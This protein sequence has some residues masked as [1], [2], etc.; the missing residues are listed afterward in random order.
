[1][2]GEIALTEEIQQL[3]TGI[4]GAQTFFSLR[5]ES[6]FETRQSITEDA[7]HKFWTRKAH[8]TGPTICFSKGIF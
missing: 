7:P 5:L 3:L 4:P 6:Q 2:Q 1:M 8:Q